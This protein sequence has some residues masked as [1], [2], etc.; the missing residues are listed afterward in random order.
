MKPLGRSLLLPKFEI[1]RDLIKFI[2]ED[3]ALNCF[4]SDLINST[5]STTIEELKNRKNKFENS[6]YHIEVYR[7]ACITRHGGLRSLSVRLCPMHLARLLH[8]IIITK[9]ETIISILKLF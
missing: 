3:G 7:I 6:D 8:L 5:S 9:S 2:L 1:K 4:P